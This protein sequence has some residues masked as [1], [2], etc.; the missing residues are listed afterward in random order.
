VTVLGRLFERRGNLNNPLVPLSAA[1]IVELLDGA[2][3][4]SGVRV[5]EKSALKFSAVWRGVAV[6]SGLG[7]AIPLHTYRTGTHKQQLVR[8]L[9]N[10]HPDLTDFEFWR[11]N[12]VHRLLWGNGYSYKLRNAVGAIVE[13]HP[14]VPERVQVANVGSSD[15][16]PPGKLFVVDG[17]TDEPLTARE[18]LHIPGLGYD[19]TCGVSP[20][21]MATTAIGMGLAAEEYGARLFGSGS[22]FS[23]ILQ[24]EQRLEEQDAKRLKASWKE[25]VGGGLSKAHEVAILDGGAKFQPISMP[26]TDAQFIESRDFQVTELSRFLGLP[27]F[28]FNQTTKSTSWGT[29]LEQQ[30]LGFVKFDLHPQW[31]RSTEARVTKELTGAG[32]YAKYKIEGLLRGDS[33]ARANFYRVMREVGA[34]SANDIRDLE[35]EPPIEGGDTYLQPLNMVPLGSEGTEGATDVPADEDDDSA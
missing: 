2:P 32:I 34:F 27:P 28:L 31:L 16:N 17:N 4:V 18:I 30:A 19:G 26:N 15:A 23:G 9:E 5:S 7:G 22:L 29:G 8:I 10:P 13:L 21:R 14:L 24:T 25:R 35:D 6:I 33:T 1:N 11:L 12:Y 3:N 20:I